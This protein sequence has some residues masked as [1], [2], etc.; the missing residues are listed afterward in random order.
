MAHVNERPSITTTEI[1]QGLG[2]VTLDGYEVGA[3]SGGV[4]TIYNQTEGV[5]VCD[6]LA[7][8][9]DAEITATSMQVEMELEQSALEKMA[10]GF[11]LHTSSVTSAASSKTL[12]VVPPT[13]IR[14][15]VLIVEGKSATNPELTQT[16]TFP[17]AVRI[18]SSQI[19]K[20]RGQK[21]TVPV[22][23]KVLYSSSIGGYCT[24]VD[25]T[26]AA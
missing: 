11:G 18:G 19:L 2:K 12:L 7:V 15:V 21:T 4:R 26:I 17:K 24:V 6:A 3:C 25:N 8:E 16:F 13:R 1:L 22:Q 9:I 5:V 10:L 23:F 14:E 20:A